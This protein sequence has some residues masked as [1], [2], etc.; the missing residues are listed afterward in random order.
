MPHFNHLVAL[1]VLAL[2]T[3][4]TVQVNI[5]ATISISAIGLILLAIFRR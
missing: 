3:S 5:D 1:S 2:C 4:G